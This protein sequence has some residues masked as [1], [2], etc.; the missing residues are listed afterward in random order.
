VL[1][2]L[3]AR[4]RGELAAHCHAW[5]TPPVSEPDG[6][7]GFLNELDE[8]TQRA[9]L[10]AVTEA[11]ERAFGARPTSFRAGRFGADG[12]TLRILEAQ[13]YLVD[14]SVTPRI[15]WRTEVGFGWGGGPDWRRC[16][17]GPYHPSRE[18]PTRPGDSS[19]VEVPLTIVRERDVFPPAVEELISRRGSRSIAERV[20]GRLGLGRI[21]W[22]RPTFQTVETMVR[23]AD[24]ATR[25][26]VDTLNLMLHSSEVLP[27]GSPFARTPAEVA[28]LLDR[29]ERAVETVLERT[30]AVPRTMSEYRRVFDGETA[31]PAEKGRAAC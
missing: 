20:I 1:A 19:L 12:A 14:S 11:H 13:G 25:Q 24:K 2:D 31:A 5:N 15:S 7:Q 4:G 21:A 22:F 6:A 16:P 29:M 3:H 28:A 9:K 27:G 8:S 30:G 10:E 26:G 23:V 17:L 18:D